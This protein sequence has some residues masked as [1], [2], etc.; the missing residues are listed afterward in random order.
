MKKKKVYK[1]KPL[2]KLIVSVLFIIFTW[3]IVTI[4]NDY[5][6]NA[7]SMIGTL[8]LILTFIVEDM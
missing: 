8:L 7:I 1:L 3:Y 5:R 4:F 2:A 6:T